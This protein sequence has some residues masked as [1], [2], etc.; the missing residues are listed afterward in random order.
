MRYKV[1]LDRLILF[2]LGLPDGYS[3]AGEEMLV[4]LQEEIARNGFREELLD[5]SDIVSL[6]RARNVLKSCDEDN[7]MYSD[8]A[9]SQKT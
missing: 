3:L 5:E 8:D 7:F 2:P 6:A 1:W 4:Q 9:S